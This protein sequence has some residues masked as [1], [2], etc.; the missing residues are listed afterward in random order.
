MI[1]RSSRIVLLCVATLAL[2]SCKG[3]KDEAKSD[4]M[5]VATPAS[6]PLARASGAAPPSDK[7]PEA[8]SADLE[9]RPKKKGKANLGY[10]DQSE[11]EDSDVADDAPSA[12]VGGKGPAGETGARSRSWFPETFL[13]QPLLVTDESGAGHLDLTVPDRLTSWR[14]LALAHSR[15][16][17]QAGSVTEFLGSLPAYV[18][19]ILPSRLRVGD[20]IR[21]PIQLVNTT[22]EAL[23]TELTVSVSGGSISAP[24]RNVTVPARGS[25]VLYATLAVTEPGEL[26]LAATLG[27]TD[28]VVRIADVVPVGKRID[29]SDSG[30]LAAPRKLTL[31]GPAAGDRVADRV[32][33]EV[34]PGALAVLRSELGASSSR[35]GIA[36]DAFTLLLSGRAPSLLAKLG[37]EPN[38]DALRTMTILATQRVVRHARVLSPESASLLAQ[39]ALAHPQN[40]ILDGLG[41]RAVGWLE[42][43]QLPDGTCGGA[44]GWTLQRLLVATADCARAAASARSVVVRAS[45][46]FERHAKQINDPYTAA[47]ILAANAAPDSVFAAALRKKIHAAVERSDSGAAWIKLPEG[48]VRAD[49]IRPSSVEASALAALALGGDADSKALVADLGATVLAGYSRR[50]GWGDGRANLVAT[51]ALVSVF[52]EPIPANVSIELS[53]DGEVVATGKLDAENVRD[54]LTL[55]ARNVGAAGKHEW[56]IK[57]EPAVAGLGFHLETSTWVAWPPQ[58]KDKGLEIDATPP[59]ELAVGQMSAWKIEV[60]APASSAFSVHLAVP[61]GVQL[62]RASI[63]AISGLLSGFELDDEQLTLHVQPVQPGQT[64]SAELR[65]IPTIAGSIQSGPQMVTMGGVSVNAPPATWVVK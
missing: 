63:E 50:Y 12:G 35:G 21:V 30:T 25:L 11:S 14:V 31:V 42:A 28:S 4:K 44:T 53:K 46:A 39:A 22:A 51:E 43:N 26:R 58:S 16:G 5:Q 2:G 36:A 1:A 7:K 57:A 40:S 10:A 34:F 17:A 13:F 32:R 60:A 49:G 23:R 18:D 59:G 37:D 55:T 41:R 6:E 47:A 61:A 8:K 38:A 33:L 27:G 24:P 29:V 9:K 52:S 62:D 20:R 56:T 65:V 54:V 15:S 45:G 48:V 3:S 64:F 19:P